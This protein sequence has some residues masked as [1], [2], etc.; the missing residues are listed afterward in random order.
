MSVFVFGLLVALW[1]LAWG[2]VS[3]ANIVSGIAL[4]AVLLLTFPAARR[5][6][7]HGRVHV[8]A[9]GRFVGYV[10]VQLVISNI[11]VAREI[12]SRRSRIRTGV[13]AYHVQHPSDLVLTLIPNVIALSPGTMAV[14]ATHDP[15]TIY[16]HFLLLSDVDE[17][18]LRI[19]R[20]ESLIVAAVGEPASPPSDNESDRSTR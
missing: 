7:P 19:A 14:D 17:A 6:R 10:L 15:A 8:L 11:L 18:R 3:V 2:D 1:L 16:V 13:I 9:L 12:L 20:L 5:A 4:A